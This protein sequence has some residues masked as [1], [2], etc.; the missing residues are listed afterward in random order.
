MV[1]PVIARRVGRTHMSVV[2]YTCSVVD[3]D[4]W[5]LGNSV[6]CRWETLGPVPWAVL[7]DTYAPSDHPEQSCRKGGPVGTAHGTGPPG[8]GPPAGDL[9]EV[10]QSV[11]QDVQR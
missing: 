6:L 5:R 7:R 3:S 10:E 9:T 11:A 1:F 2:P 8:K 4:P